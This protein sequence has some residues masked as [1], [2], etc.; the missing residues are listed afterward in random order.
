MFDEW[1]SSGHARA[2]ETDLFTAMQ[3]GVDA[4]SCDPCHTPLKGKVDPGEL[5][6]GEGVT[7]EVC[8]TIKDVRVGSDGMAATVT[9]G[10]GENVER[11]PL[12]DAPDH[13]FHKMGCS[14]LHRESRVCAGCHLWSATRGSAPPMPIFTEFDEWQK[15]PSAKAGI[16]CQDCHMPGASGEVARGSP[17]RPNVANHSFMGAN[18]G[19]RDRAIALTLD[20]SDRNG[21]LSVDVTLVNQGAGHSVPG[22]LP[23]RQLIL[24]VATLDKAGNETDRA[25][26]IYARVLVDERSVEVPFPRARS[27]LSDRRIAAGER[28]REAFSL[29]AP[30][31]GAG[32]VRLEVALR[33]ISPEIAAALARPAPE[34]RVVARVEVPFGAPRAAG[35]RSLLPKRV[36]L[37]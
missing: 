20:V 35:G 3:A 19:F 28:R 25:E 5:A 30:A 10:L 7:C 37:P 27:L 26:R 8:H 9:Y 1:K 15:G 21:A 24:R 34:L 23:G 18:A 12:C 33:A 31:T 36:T 11:G 22:G 17:T 16:S 13:Y 6:L 29:S 2:S 32:S 4:S 14:P